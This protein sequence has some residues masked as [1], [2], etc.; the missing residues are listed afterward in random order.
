MLPPHAAGPD[1]SGLVPQVPAVRGAVQ[2]L[3]VQGT[4]WAV[5]AGGRGGAASGAR[6]AVLSLGNW[7]CGGWGGPLALRG[8]AP[9]GAEG[10]CASL[11]L[12]PR[13]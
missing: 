8:C 6:R 13:L 9:C 7:C 4:R 5:G 11:G 1:G 3:R 12:L 2:P 10:L